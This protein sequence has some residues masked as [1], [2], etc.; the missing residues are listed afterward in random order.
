VETDR[1]PDRDGKREEEEER[2]RERERIK[3][4]TRGPRIKVNKQADKT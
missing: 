1:Q 4:E 3:K 2:A